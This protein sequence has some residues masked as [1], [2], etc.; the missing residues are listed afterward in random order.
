MLN[1]LEAIEFLGFSFLTRGL[2]CL[3]NPEKKINISKKPY[4]FIRGGGG[5]REAGKS[6]TIW[7][8]ILELRGWE[9]SNDL[10][11]N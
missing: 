7:K 8:K 5:G 1:I 3:R 4:L 9:I 2:A 11:K 10:K 6:T